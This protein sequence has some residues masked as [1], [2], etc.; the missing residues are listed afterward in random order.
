[1]MN[2]YTESNVPGSHT[3]SSGHLNM[4]RQ[5]EI[6]EAFKSDRDF[7]GNVGMAELHTVIRG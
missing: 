6:R 7:N 5:G 3:E 2:V 4:A 1:M